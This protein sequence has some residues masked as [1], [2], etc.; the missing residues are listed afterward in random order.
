MYPDYLVHFNKN[1]SSKNGQFTSGD[2]DGDGVS[3]DHAHRS[4]N[5]GK[6]KRKKMTKSQKV[7]LG[8]AI[9]TGVATAA[10]IGAKLVMDYRNE[11]AS[12]EFH[13]QISRDFVERQNQIKWREAASQAKFAGG[14]W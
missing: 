9:G 14:D 8:F 1:H 5:S 13:D 2:G 11:K 7:S 12:K 3:D 4:K 6:E 10:I